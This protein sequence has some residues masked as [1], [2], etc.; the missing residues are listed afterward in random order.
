MWMAMSTRG[1]TPLYVDLF[2]Q[3]VHGTDL[4]F[5]GIIIVHG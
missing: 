4:V 2:W 5:M 1:A 3:V